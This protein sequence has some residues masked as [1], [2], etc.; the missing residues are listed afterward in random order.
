V[1]TIE[2]DGV[3]QDASRTHQPWCDPAQHDATG[4]DDCASVPVE[5]PDGV[6]AWREMRGDVSGWR[7]L[8]DTFVPAARMPA[9]GERLAGL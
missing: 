7:V 2:T 1:V 3:E 4:R 9:L 6:T 5:L 8:A